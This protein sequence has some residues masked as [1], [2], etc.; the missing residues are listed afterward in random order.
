[1]TDALPKNTYK[2]RNRGQF[3][4]DSYAA[5]E[6]ARQMGRKGGQNSSKRTKKIHPVIRGEEATDEE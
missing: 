2:T 1:M 5:Q 6:H 4:S 3:S